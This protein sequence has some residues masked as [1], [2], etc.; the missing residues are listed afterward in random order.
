MNVAH[1]G[2]PRQTS[3]LPESSEINGGWIIYTPGLLWEK[4]LCSA[5]IKV[6]GW[7]VLRGPFRA[8]EWTLVDVGQCMLWRESTFSNA[9][10]DSCKYNSG[11]VTI[12]RSHGTMFGA[13]F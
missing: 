5:S 1:T 8:A 3:G 12:P 11:D 6:I 2:K 9:P 4:C 7:A 10:P 13:V